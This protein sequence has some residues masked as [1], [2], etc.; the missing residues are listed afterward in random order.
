MTKPLDHLS[1]DLL[2]EYAE[3]LLDAPARANADVHL[4]SCEACRQELR[5]VQGYFTDMAALETVRAP[6]NFLSKVRARVEK[7][8]P[9]KTFWNRLSNPW[10]LIPAQLALLTLLGITVLTV[11]LQQPGGPL[12]KETPYSEPMAPAKEMNAARE[13]NR[14]DRPEEKPEKKRKENL[15][16][17]PSKQVYAKDAPSQADELE[18]GAK[19]DAEAPPAE[20]KVAAG[21]GSSSSSISRALEMDRPLAKAEAPASQRAP[22]APSSERAASRAFG[23]TEKDEAE[24][25]IILRLNSGQDTTAL[26]I[27]L[28]AMGA[29]ASRNGNQNSSHGHGYR[30][31]LHASMQKDFRTYLDRYGKVEDQKSVLSGTG[32][33][34]IHLRLNVI[35]P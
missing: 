17:T 32:A 34:E 28:K 14:E 19:S 11:Y 4:Q 20:K 24:P 7:P 12:T 2:C 5:V 25:D 35:L 8:S 31:S 27:G 26:L 16:S 21:S 18:S 22:M 1:G 33:S 29:T 3:G 30:V 23:A 13:E 6:A 10:R 9:L 15:G